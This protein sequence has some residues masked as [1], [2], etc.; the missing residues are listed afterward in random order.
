MAGLLIREWKKY[1]VPRYFKANE[2]ARKSEILKGNA[3]MR[4]IMVSECMFAENTPVLLAG[5][6][7]KNISYS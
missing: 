6:E 5:T 2:L 7:V 3:Q 4:F 1:T